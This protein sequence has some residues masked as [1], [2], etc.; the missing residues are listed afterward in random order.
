[1]NPDE[2]KTLVE[3]LVNDKTHRFGIYILIACCVSILITVFVN[4]LTEK[5]KNWATKQDI[6][7]ITNDI[8]QA[9]AI[10]QND[11]EVVKLKREL[12]YKA[13]LASLNIIDAHLSNFL[14]F[15]DGNTPIDKQF[16]TAIQARE[17]HNN[18]VLTIENPQLLVLFMKIL[19]AE[20]GLI[21]SEVELLLDNVN[22]YRNLVRKELGFGDEI[23]LTDQA[24]W[25]A[26]VNFSPPVSSD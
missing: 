19:S 15:P 18:L 10:I 22:K 5:G 7:A 17:C 9:K 26:K 21:S 8:E 16:A 20:K 2:I 11:Q 13:L 25:F 3:S 12:K 23:P 1:M 4:Y 14:I 24:I 6:K